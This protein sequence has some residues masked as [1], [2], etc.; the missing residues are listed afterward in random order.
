[1][2]LAGGYLL[3][4]LLAVL[5]VMVSKPDAMSGL[6]LM[7]LTIPWSFILFETI[8]ENWAA[9]LGPVGFLGIFAVSVSI[10]AAIL[11]FV[12][13]LFTWTSA[14]LEDRWKKNNQK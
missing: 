2:I 12:G 7:V 14:S 5:S 10:N 9:V 1:M 6:A 11:Y 8:P 13:W 3:L 4:F